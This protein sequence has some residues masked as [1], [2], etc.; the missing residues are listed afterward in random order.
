M[1][2]GRDPREAQNLDSGSSPATLGA[3]LNAR[4]VELQIAFPSRPSLAN[5]LSEPK[6]RASNAKT[7]KRHIKPSVTGRPKT[8]MGQLSQALIGSSMTG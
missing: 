6:E 5:Q 7:P 2:G 3:F 8:A 4:E 1:P